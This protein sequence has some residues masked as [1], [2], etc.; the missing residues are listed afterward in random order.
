MRSVGG[1]AGHTGEQMGLHGHGVTCMATETLERDF[2]A[3]RGQ[4]RSTPETGRDQAKSDPHGILDLLK[5]LDV[6]PSS[7][8]S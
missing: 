2:G 3:S 1:T 7:N 4:S 6:D 8:H 5:L